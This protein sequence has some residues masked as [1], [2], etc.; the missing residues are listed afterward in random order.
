MSKPQIIIGIITHNRKNQL[1]QLLRTLHSQIKNKK[2]IAIYVLENGS[3]DIVQQELPSDQVTLVNLP[4]A[5]IPIARNFIFNATK[6]Y[7]QKLVFIDDDC[8]PNKDWVRRLEEISFQRNVAAVQGKVIS[9]PKENIYAQVTGALYDQWI[10]SFVDSEYLR[11]ILDTKNI[12]LNL[13][14][15]KRHKKLFDEKVGFASD[16]VLA[17][18]LKRNNF[19]VLYLP[20]L[21]VFHQERT[22]LLDFLQHRFRLSVSYRLQ[23]TEA[24]LDVSSL[25]KK[26]KDV[27]KKIQRPALSKFIILSLLVVVHLAVFFNLLK[28]KL[29]NFISKIIK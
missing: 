13:K 12:V 20:S 21:I 7:A 14:I 6:P 16:V 2:N 28:K 17:Q 26:Y 11:E 19:S 24:A 9:I 22:R 10:D 4:K 23:H 25:W 15:F 5:S 27:W 29:F 3:H 8:L 1:L 18:M